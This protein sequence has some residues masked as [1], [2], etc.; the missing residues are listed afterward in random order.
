MAHLGVS[1]AA[2]RKIRRRLEDHFAEHWPYMT[3]TDVV[4]DYVKPMTVDTHCRCG[5]R[6]PPAPSARLRESAPR[7]ALPSVPY[8]TRTR[9]LLEIELRENV[10]L[11]YN[12]PYRGVARRSTP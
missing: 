4:L 11:D 10:A 6:P 9:T 3:T 2:L 7:C 12:P 5:A 8:T 1:K